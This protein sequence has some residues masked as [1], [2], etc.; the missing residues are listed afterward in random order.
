MAVNNLM[1]GEERAVSS[2][3]VC[4]YSSVKTDKKSLRTV[5]FGSTQSTWGD[6]ND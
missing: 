6:K 5:A 4:L 3:H 1:T 2:E